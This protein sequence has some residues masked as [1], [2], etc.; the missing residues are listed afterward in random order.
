MTENQNANIILDAVSRVRGTFER[1]VI[2]ERVSEE[3]P[4]VDRIQR[5]RATH[6][7]RAL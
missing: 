5:E 1:A 3:A 4:A 6:R 7:E 2:L